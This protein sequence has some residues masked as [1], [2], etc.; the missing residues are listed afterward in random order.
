MSDQTEKLEDPE[1][2]AAPATSRP[3]VLSI[4][5]KEKAGL[6][7]AFM[8]FLVNGGIFVPTKKTFQMSEQVYL[9]VSLM[10]DPGKYPLVGTVAWI[11]PEK[12]NS[13]K[14][15]GVGVHFPGDESGRR[16][17]LRIEEILGSAVGS[18]RSTHTL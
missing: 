4:S 8:P 14:A 5:I 7:A 6:C 13:G 18:S 11:T 16:I 12:S 10:D 17:K 2:I 9:I 1:V 3:A 15:P